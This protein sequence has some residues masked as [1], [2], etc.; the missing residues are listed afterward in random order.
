M[1]TTLLTIG[2]WSICKTDEGANSQAVGGHIRNRL[3]VYAEHSTNCSEN[4]G[5]NI[6]A[7]WSYEFDDKIDDHE[8]YEVC[9]QCNTR[10]PDEVVALVQLYNMERR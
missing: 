10:V 3:E 2:D 9:W 7:S 4:I 5:S 1:F 8:G 6:S